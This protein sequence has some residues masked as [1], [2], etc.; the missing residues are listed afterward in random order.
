M[1]LS[2][3]KGTAEF[4]LLSDFSLALPKSSSFGK[5]DFTTDLAGAVKNGGRVG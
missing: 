5:I 2:L 3:E 1:D 4:C